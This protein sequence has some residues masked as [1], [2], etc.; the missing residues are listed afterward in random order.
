MTSLR[1]WRQA[2]HPYEREWYPQDW[3]LPMLG[4]Q[5]YRLN[6]YNQAL[7]NP[8]LYGL[9]VCCC[10]LAVYTLGLRFGAA[11]KPEMQFWPQDGKQIAQFVESAP[12]TVF[13]FILCDPER[14]LHLR[15]LSL[16]VVDAL[17]ILRRQS[18]LADYFHL[19]QEYT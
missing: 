12:Y 13:Y 7:D 11:L 8:D 15:F 5:F 16:P 10:P 19:T 4:N 18:P 2:V 17:A 14:P 9:Y 3:L 6:P 1:I